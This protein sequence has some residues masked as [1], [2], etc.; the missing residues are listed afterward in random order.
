MFCAFDGPPGILRLHGRGSV[1]TSGDPG[2]ADLLARFP[3]LPGVRSIIRVDV[4]RIAD[5]CGFGVPQYKFVG[6]RDQLANWTVAKG[7][8]ALADSRKTKNAVSLDGLP[9]LK[10]PFG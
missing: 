4:Q 2:F 3:E 5:S 10:P 9:G 6:D 7:D 1:V 8:A